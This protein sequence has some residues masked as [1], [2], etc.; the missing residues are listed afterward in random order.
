MPKI[1]TIYE[2]TKHLFD[3]LEVKKVISKEGPSQIDVP[4]VFSGT[5][6]T[7]ARAYQMLKLL[8]LDEEAKAV[9]SAINGKNTR[10]FDLGY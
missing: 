5:T 6:E 8:G 4:A 1:K 9:I 7:E 2:K 10:V 3:P